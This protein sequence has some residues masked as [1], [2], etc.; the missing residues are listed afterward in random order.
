MHET[1][2][3]LSE[4]QVMYEAPGHSVE[5]MGHLEEARGLMVEAW[6]SFDL[7]RPKV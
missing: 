7:G 3:L 6:V 5:P 4:A 2:G 1:P